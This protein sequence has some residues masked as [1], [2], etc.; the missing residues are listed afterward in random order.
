MKKIG[1]ITNTWKFALDCIKS[2]NT[3]KAVEFLDTCLLI[4]AHA[5]KEGKIQL[6]NVKVDTWKVRVWVKLEELNVI[7]EY[8]EYI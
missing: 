2:N 7:P 4:L 8:D 6:D 3:E 5:T 1:K